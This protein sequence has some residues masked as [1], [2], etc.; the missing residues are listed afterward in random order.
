MA[1]KK[2]KSNMQRR[3]KSSNPASMEEVMKH[4]MTSVDATEPFDEDKA[5][6]LMESLR[7]AHD[8][9][10][11]AEF[12]K[13]KQQLEAMGCTVRIKPDNDFSVLFPPSAF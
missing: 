4:F 2:R 10:D 11:D 5:F 8:N 9:N 3:D 6:K 7:V 13:I 1:K 12:Q